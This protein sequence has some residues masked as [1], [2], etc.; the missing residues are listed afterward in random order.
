MKQMKRFAA[1]ALTGAMALSL[2][3]CGSGDEKPTPGA[4]PTPSATPAQ[5][6]S[7]TASA[8][9]YGGD[10]TV[11]LTVAGTTVDAL[12]AEGPNET[13]NIGGAA[14]VTFNEAFAALSGKEVS[15]LT[16]DLD[17]V[18]G[19]TMTSTA[20][21]SALRDVVNQANGI[22]ES[23]RA[24]VSD[25]TATYQASG[26]SVTTPVSVEVALKDNAISSITVGENGETA[27]ILQ[28]VID[29]LIP[30]ILESQSLAVDSIAGATVSS[31]A[32]KNAV[33]QAIDANGG[34]SAQWYTPVEK[35][36]DTVTLEGYDVIVVGLGGSGM[37][38]YV[39]AA[40]NGAAVFGLDT[41]AKIGGTSTNVSGPMAINPQSKMDAQ[42]GGEKF[43]EEEDLIADWLEYCKGDAKE[44]IVR[45]FV[46]E[47]GETMDWLINDYGFAFAEIKA[48]F[49]PKMWPVWAVYE[50]DKTTM[51]TSA[52]D[53]A[54]AMNEKNDYMLELTATDLIT[55]GG[56]VVGVKA[57]Y[58]DGTTYEIYGDSVILATGGFLGNAEM[59]EE[60]LG[61][62]FSAEAMLQNKGA[63]VQMAMALGAGTYNIDMPGMVHIAQTKTIIKSDELTADQKAVLS[64]LVLTPE[65]M[66]VGTDGSRF[67]SEA[68]NIAFDNWK[69]GDTYYA[70]YSQAQMDSFRE[71]GMLSP[72]APMFLNQGG[73]VEANTPI[74]D[75]DAILAV[76]E[77]YNIV[78]KADTLEELASKLGVDVTNLTTAAAE[79]TSAANGEVEDS[80]GKDAS[81]MSSLAEGS[82][83]AVA[84]AGY[85]YG[86]C[87]G[88]DI[89]ADM[90]VL[91]TDGTAF[92]NLYAVGQDSMGVLFSNQVPYVTYGGAAQ[93]WVITSGRLAG[94]N[95]AAA[96]AGE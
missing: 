94:A 40:E 34:D 85:Y 16:A 13:E 33:A 58:H 95:A 52:V 62:T 55:D 91:K 14:I 76:G 65:S 15:S 24:P 42:N 83:Y 61:G 75:L 6:A 70:I 21:K 26:N 36:T 9:G 87:G 60:Y 25:S 10:V 27:S 64:A 22:E 35:K 19:A 53:K 49:H 93:G 46:N 7:Y 8:K 92:E 1:L 66:I 63:G 86:T 2:A 20:V 68:G 67:M 4:T 73:T 23:G 80:F 78:T 77:Q 90:Q 5:T 50:G 3:A 29:N 96:F 48:F 47:S 30:R 88:L 59:T 28:T 38:S 51:F 39:S 79:Y 37:T 11:K 82:Y 44:D 71:N 84:G 31:G 43:V 54:K 74:A 69:G 57:V 32:V 81:L 56:K 45:E 89:N 41:A 17:A 72:A 18:S 12:T